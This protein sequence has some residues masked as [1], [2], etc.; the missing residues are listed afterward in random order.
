M[1]H[2]LL[3]LALNC[4][5]FHPASCTSQ[6]EQGNWTPEELEGGLVVELAVSLEG[7]LQLQFPLGNACFFLWFYGQL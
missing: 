4:T 5:Q 2:F 1:T 3:S 6:A 7:Q